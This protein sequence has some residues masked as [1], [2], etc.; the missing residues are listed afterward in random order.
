MQLI[1]MM[2][3]IFTND[4]NLDVQTNTN[5]KN[6]RLAFEIKNKIKLAKPLTSR[7]TTLPKFED[8]I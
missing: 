3:I 2:I 7:L 8:W 5:C 4:L 1:S 6:L